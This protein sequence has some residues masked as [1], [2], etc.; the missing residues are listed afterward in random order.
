MAFVSEMID[1]LRDLLD[2]DDDS[3]VA[4]ATKR[5]YLN[6]GIIR[7]WPRIYRIREVTLSM[8]AGE[9]EYTLTDLG[10]GQ[11]LSAEY[12]HDSDVENYRTMMRYR[13]TPSDEDHTATLYL[14]FNPDDGAE[15]RIKWIAAVPAITAASYA[16]AEAEVWTGPDRAIGL[17][18]LYAMGMITARKLDNRQDHTRMSTTQALNGVTDQDIMGAA[19]MW[20]GQFEAELAELERPLP[21]AKD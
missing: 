21:I 4:F 13:I 17:P 7:L 19:Q 6:R 9:Y 15:V 14:G 8:T 1:Q 10:E 12:S 18:V 2:D 3:Q 5:L 16:A 11:V 20:F